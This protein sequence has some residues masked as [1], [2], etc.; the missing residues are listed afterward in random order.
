MDPIPAAGHAQAD[1]VPTKVAKISYPTMLRVA[2][3]REGATLPT[4]G[5]ACSAG[6]D[7]SACDPALIPK[8]GRGIVQTGLA[9]ATPANTY[10][11]L[12]PRSGL[13]VR[14]GIQVGAGVIRRVRNDLADQD[15]R[16]EVGVVLFNHGDEDLQVSPGDR[17][18]QLILE[19]IETPEVQEVPSIE[20]LGATGSIG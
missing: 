9:I 20:L 13:A 6:Y 4:R 2:K 15:Y 17:V 11:R 10:A 19:R 14:Q 18:A 3:L 1:E 12:V 7:L 16:G 5:S 8:G